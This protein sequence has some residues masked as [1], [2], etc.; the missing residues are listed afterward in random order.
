MYGLKR[1]CKKGLK[2]WLEKFKGKT[3]LQTIVR[4][5]KYKEYVQIGNIIL[6]Y[7]VNTWVAIGCKTGS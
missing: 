6:I 3:C 5:E 7:L 4:Y 2:V 1:K